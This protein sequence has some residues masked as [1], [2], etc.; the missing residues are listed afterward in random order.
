MIYTHVLRY[1]ARGVRSPLDATER[2][3]GARTPSLK[4]QACPHQATFTHG[5]S[6]HATRPS[7]AHPPPYA[8]PPS[9][10]PGMFH[11]ETQ[12]HAR[13]PLLREPGE[14]RVSL[15]A[16]EATEYNRRMGKT[17]RSGYLLLSLLL[18]T[19]AMSMPIPPRIKRNVAFLYL[20]DSPGSFAPL[21]TAFFVAI[22]DD[23]TGHAHCYLVTAKHV[24]QGPSG[25]GF[26]RVSSSE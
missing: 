11:R 1:G 4:I 3:P 23:S 13:A 6:R 8:P 2:P 5:V 25:R 9:H 7:H 15:G 14:V 17:S 16:P 26:C 12:A 18:A 10:S 22:K 19:T 20:A 24:I 21:G